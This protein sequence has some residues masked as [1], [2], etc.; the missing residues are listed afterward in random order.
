ML[1]V[2]ILQSEINIQIF[3]TGILDMDI[4]YNVIVLITVNKVISPDAL[5]FCKIE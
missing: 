5:K 4:N 3:L 2:Y 1:Q